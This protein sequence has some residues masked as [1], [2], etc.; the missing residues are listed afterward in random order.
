M[1]QMKDVYENWDEKCVPKLRFKMDKMDTK[2]GLKM[3]TRTG[4]KHVYRDWD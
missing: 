1:I 4:I 3:C 2:L